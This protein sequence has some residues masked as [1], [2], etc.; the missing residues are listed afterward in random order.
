MSQPRTHTLTRKTGDGPPGNERDP[1]VHS[2]LH[3]LDAIV[4]V[5]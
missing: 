1:L 4:A 5:P 2:E 3:Q